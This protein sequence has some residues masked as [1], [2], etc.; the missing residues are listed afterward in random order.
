M[1]SEQ[2]F[3]RISKEVENQEDKIVWKDHPLG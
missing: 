2:Y 3:N 1:K